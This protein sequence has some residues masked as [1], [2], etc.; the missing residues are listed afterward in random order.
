MSKRSEAGQLG[1]AIIL[2]VVFPLPFVAFF[3]IGEFFLGG[4]K[5]AHPEILLAYIGFW[6]WIA[7]DFAAVGFAELWSSLRSRWTRG[8]SNHRS[9]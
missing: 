1:C 3:V 2:I 7:W 4:T 5:E 9:E 6:F 8:G